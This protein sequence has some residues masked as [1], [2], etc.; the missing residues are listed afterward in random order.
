MNSL[1][2]IRLLNSELLIA[3]LVVNALE[4]GSINTVPTNIKVPQDEMF[5]HFLMFFN[6]QLE[7]KCTL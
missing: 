4:Q 2:M 7:Y 6:L 1:I 3:L 5:L